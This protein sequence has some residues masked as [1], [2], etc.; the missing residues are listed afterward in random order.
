MATKMPIAKTKRETEK[1]TAGL[2]LLNIRIS[3]SRREFMPRFRL[4]RG[5]VSYAASRSDLAFRQRL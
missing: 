3:A 1:R 5:I 4:R 2:T